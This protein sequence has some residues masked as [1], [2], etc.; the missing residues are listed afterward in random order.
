MDCN[1]FGIGLVVWILAS[2][3]AILG[4]G[5]FEYCMSRRVQRIADEALVEM[6]AFWVDLNRHLSEQTAQRS[7]HA[8]RREGE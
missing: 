1:V 6:D 7:E 2:A 5:I 3:A 8:E 4:A